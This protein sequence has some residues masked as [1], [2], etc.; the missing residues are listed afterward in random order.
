MATSIFISEDKLKSSS[1]INGNVD[2]ELLKPYLK[3][4]QDLHLHPV[5]G[6]DLYNAI[7][8]GIQNTSLTSAETT[9]LN[10]YI[11]DALKMK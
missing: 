9:L 8:D 1:T 5:L 3:V 11:A 2:A 4:A 6:T 10:D 7:Q